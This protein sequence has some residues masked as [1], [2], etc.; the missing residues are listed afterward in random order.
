[1]TTVDRA[2]LLKGPAYLTHDSAVIKFGAD[3]SVDLV[4]E[5]FEVKSISH[6][7]LGRRIKDRKVEI[8]GVPLE[9]TDLTKLFPYATHQPG[10]AV[11]GA[12]DKAAVITPRTGAPLTVANVMVTK[13]PGLSLH[14]S[15]AMLRDMEFTGLCANASDPAT[16]ASFFSFGVAAAGVAQTAATLA[17]IKNAFYSATFNSVTYKPEDGFEV[18]FN[19]PL[20]PDMQDGLTVGMRISPEESVEAA[21]K[22]KPLG[23]TEAQYAT[24][25]GWDTFGPGDDPFA[26]NL[27]ISG[28]A[29][30]KPTVTLSK[31]QV[32]QGGVRYG[33]DSR[34]GE[35]TLASVRQIST[36]ALTALWTFDTVA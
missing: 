7:R 36:N 25:M 35:V 13:L 28:H 33:R 22:F 30:G 5:Y 23:L 29:T 14:P 12:T 21:V 3:F 19:L 17:N 8:K 11:F 32:M 24:L 34:A 1:M 10:D 4:T 6:G 27:V 9:W 16:A 26:G 31:M 2:N 20:V 15:K 18:D